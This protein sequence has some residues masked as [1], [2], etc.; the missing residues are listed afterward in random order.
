[1]TDRAAD[2]GAV[3]EEYGFV[4]E[5]LFRA[6]RAEVLNGLL[7]L[8]HLFHTPTARDRYEAN[9]RRNIGTELMLLNA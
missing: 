6:G 3:R 1:V 5:D 8:P 9:A 4:P 2:A 7:A